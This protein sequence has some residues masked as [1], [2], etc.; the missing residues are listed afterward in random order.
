MPGT[1]ASSFSAWAAAS[2]SCWKQV[3][4][5]LPSTLS[6]KYSN[7]CAGF[8]EHL[9]AISC[10]GFRAQDV[11]EAGV[12][13]A[14]MRALG[15]SATALRAAGFSTEGMMIAGYNAKE[16]LAAGCRYSCRDGFAFVFD[17][18]CLLSAA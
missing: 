5:P 6:T 10:G 4:Q 1:R 12:T 7:V 18:T 16:L 14:Q 3:I 2:A 15:C 9:I 17:C 13:A 8:H 11:R